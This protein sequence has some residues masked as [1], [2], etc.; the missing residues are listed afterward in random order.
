MARLLL[1]GFS[2]LLISSCGFHLKGHN[3]ATHAQLDAINVN[4]TQGSDELASQLRHVFAQHNI[5]IDNNASTRLTVGAVEVTARNLSIATRNTDIEQEL[6]AR[7][8]ATIT[9][10]IVLREEFTAAIVYTQAP[11]SKL[12]ADRELQRQRRLLLQQLAEQ[13]LRRV[14][15]LI[16]AQQRET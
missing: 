8:K 4:F 3:P 7:V 14:D 2:L 9:H 16:M 10:G 1:I 6:Q 11:S 5:A 13:I 15:N 12:A